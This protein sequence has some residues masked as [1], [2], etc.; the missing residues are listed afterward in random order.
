MNISETFIRKPIM[1]SLVM[2]AA[3]IFGFFAY[4]TLPVSDLPVVD[5]PVITISVSYPG[6]SPEMMASTVATPLENQCMQIPGLQSIISSNTEGQTNIT[7]TFDLSRNVDLAAP[8]VEAAIS[9]AQANLP[10]DLPQP[11]TYDK[12]NPSDQ[13]IVHVNVTS[14]TL[15]DGQLYD[16]GNTTIG[17]RLNMLKGVS[18]VDVWGSQTAVRIQVDPNKLSSYRIGID[19]VAAAIKSGTVIIPGGSLNGPVHTFSIEPQG[20][21][22]KAREYGNLIIKYQDNSPVY[23]RDVATCIDSVKDDVVRVMT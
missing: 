9:R 16:F 8:D 14:D 13:P 1:T 23:L 7:L 4:I 6:A 5:Y 15:T 12:D 22:L 17:E 2:M 18:K 19:E 21:L 3:L 11:P 10:D 20:Q